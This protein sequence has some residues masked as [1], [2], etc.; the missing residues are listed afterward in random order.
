MDI[1]DR[2]VARDESEPESESEDAGVGKH[3]RERRSLV[4]ATSEQ[5]P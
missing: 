5:S 2:S 1:D 4:T 3:A